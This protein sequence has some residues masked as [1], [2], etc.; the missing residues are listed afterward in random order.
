MNNPA[1]A[2]QVTTACDPSLR[3]F[4]GQHLLIRRTKQ[5]GQRLGLN[6]RISERQFFLLKYLD[7]ATDVRRTSSSGTFVA[8][9]F[10]RNQRH[11][12]RELEGKAQGKAPR[13]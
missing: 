12:K 2:D 8:S 1:L 13:A 9:S 4:S 11:V 6:K 7:R 10:Y 5:I 3:G